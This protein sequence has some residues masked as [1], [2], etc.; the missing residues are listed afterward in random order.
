MMAAP[1]VANAVPAGTARTG[2]TQARLGGRWIRLA[3][4][5]LAAT[6][7][8]AAIVASPAAAEQPW[9]FE[10]VT[11]PVKGSGALAY[12]DTFQSSP[13]GESFLYTT[14]SAFTDIP[15]ESSPAYV[16]YLGIR[17]ADSWSN[18]SLDPPYDTGLG[19]QAAFDILGVV[20]TSHDLNYALVASSSALTPGATEGGGNLYLRNTHTRELTLVATSSSRLLSSIMNSN[21]GELSV[22]YVGADGVSFVT[23]LGLTPGA[24]DVGPTEAGAIYAWTPSDGLEAVSVMPE[25]EGGE[26]IAAAGAGNAAE[27]GA[28][29]SMAYEGGLDH[30]YFQSFKDNQPG[31]LYVR[32]G[33]VTK[34]VSFSRLSGAPGTDL[35]AVSDAVAN[36]GRYLLF[37]T[38]S[39]LTEDTPIAAPSTGGY[40]YRYDASDE[41]LTYIGINGSPSTTQ[42]IQMSQDGQTIAFQSEKAQAPSASE[43]QPNV[44]IWR[45][46]EPELKL[47]ATL[48]SGSSGSN[49]ATSLRILSENGRYLAFTDSSISLAEEFGQENVS[50]SCPNFLEEP[51]PCDEVYVYD[52]DASS[53]ALQCASCSQDGAPPIGDSGDALNKNQGYMRTNAH[54]MQIVAND[55]TVFFTTFNGLLPTD[56][57]E[58]EDV[59]AYDDGSLRLVSRATPGT[60]ARFL[61]ASPDGKAVFIST[62]DAIVGTDTD[63]SVDVYLT[64]EGAGYP[65]TP[66]VVT[67]P[68]GNAETCH[69]GLPGVPSQ[70]SAGTASFQGRGNEV[71]PPGAKLTVAKAKPFAGPTGSLRV[72][73]STKGKLKVSGAGLAPV[74]QAA[75]KGGTY[76]VQVKLVPAARKALRHSGHLRKRV[77]VTFTPTG[78]KASVRTVQLTFKSSGSKKRRH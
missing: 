5:S 41:S 16:R 56:Q 58:A 43:G 23:N 42:V 6:I 77:K 30:I 55:G 52:A 51:G 61:D 57:N 24:P 62:N 7:G 4:V 48:E 71:A 59:Y 45:D 35:V 68:C 75:P 50:T 47:A 1:T 49:Q 2:S 72:K 22:R 76:T 44:Y 60:S 18:V 28:R 40:L 33:D 27:T 3:L 20:G 38:E 34:P 19:S 53:E 10:Q 46:G 11:P 31:G 21:M 13:D 8:T 64:R 14:N 37:H 65:F 54:Q 67:P 70:G 26:V 73:V 12:V 78:G 9:G 69:E 39:R 36:N 15:S 66:P 17:G 32:S 63:H 25:S 29:N 74:S